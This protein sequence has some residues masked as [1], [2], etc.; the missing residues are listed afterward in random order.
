M[1]A[2][3]ATTRGRIAAF[4]AAITPGTRLVAISHVLWT[5]GAVMPVAAIA[6]IA[7]ARGALLILDGAQAAGAIP[8]R[9]DETGRRPL[10]G[11]RPEVAARARRGWAPSSSRPSIADRLRP[12]LG[13]NY[14]FERNDSAGTADWWPDARRF[15]A[16]NYHRPSVVGMARSLGWLSMYVG[17]EFIYRTGM[18]KARGHGPAAGGDPRGDRP[19][20]DRPHGDARSRSGSP[21]G[22]R[23]PR[24]RSS[25]RGSSRSP[26]R[27]PASTRCGSASGSST[28]TRS[29]SGWPGR[30]SCSRRTRPRHCRLA[31]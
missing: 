23:G 27:S 24:S 11:L 9:F 16:S 2:P 14:S 30:S 7:H 19:D 6:E 26:G 18:A 5:T 12:A 3:T 13:G 4:D 20:A 29:S 17:L 31:A 21:D 1:P 28:P 22:R 25:V 15:E 10:R 8:F